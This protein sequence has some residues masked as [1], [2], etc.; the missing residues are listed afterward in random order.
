[1]KIKGLTIKDIMEIDPDDLL[2]M[3]RQE[4][5]SITNRLI[6][7]SN[8]RI[9]RLEQTSLGRTSPAYVSA[10]KRDNGIFSIR[11]KDL[12]QVRHVFARA[13]GFLSMKT[14]TVGGWREVREDVENRLGG[15][16]T[17][18]ESKKF[19][20]SYRELEERSGGFLDKSYKGRTGL[21]SDQVQSMLY[22]TLDESG[23]RTRRSNI[24]D[25]VSG[26]LKDIYE[27]EELERKR[28]LELE[29]EEEFELDDDEIDY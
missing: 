26:K 4:L 29:D 3:N 20:K 15:E 11:G 17:E 19:W 27:D 22:Q 25:T 18:Y 13:K 24:V 9:R 8:K 12:N 1:M 21:T 6:S 28:Q 7:A 16:M 14:S 23:W 5:A 10:S 2:K